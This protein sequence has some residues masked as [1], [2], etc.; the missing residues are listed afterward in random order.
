[1]LAFD[2]RGALLVGGGSAEGRS[3]EEVARV[4]VDDDD[5]CGA[6][7]GGGKGFDRS[8]VKGAAD[9]D[10]LT[11]CGKGGTGGGGSGGASAFFDEDGARVR[12]KVIDRDLRSVN[13]S[14]RRREPADEGEVT[15]D[16]GDGDDDL[17]GP[18]AGNACLGCEDE[19]T[20][21]CARCGVLSF[22]GGGL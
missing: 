11:D 16:A 15:D 7:G 1:M 21:S 18:G 17:V 12:S 4:V 19:G 8:A 9:K 5:D 6:G 3:E 22:G 20:G 10:C 2:G 13:D 14:L